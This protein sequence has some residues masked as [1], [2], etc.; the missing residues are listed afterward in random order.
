GVEGGR[1]WRVVGNLAGA[2]GAAVVIADA[3][4]LRVHSDAGVYGLTV[5]L[6]KPYALGGDDVT[7]TLEAEA[8]WILAT[9]VPPG[10]TVDVLTVSGGTIEFRPRLTVG[11]LGL[12]MGRSSGPLLDAGITIDSVAVHPHA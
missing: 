9:G 4:E 11:G 8:S 1:A 10:L 3:L 6:L 2:R 5:G 7:F 12:R